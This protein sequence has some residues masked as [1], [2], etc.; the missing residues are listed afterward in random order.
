MLQIIMAA[1]FLLL[2]TAT[3]VLTLTGTLGS[4]E[5][6]VSDLID[7]MI[8]PSM[9]N[10]MKIITC[11]GS[12]PVLC[13]LTVLLVLL[14]QTRK[15]FGCPVAVTAM[16]SAAL[17]LVLKYCFQRPRPEVML[18]AETGYSFPSG[19]AQSGMAFF[20]AVALLIFCNIGRLK[21]S[22]PLFVFCMLMPLL[23][24]FSRLYFG[25]HYA[26]DVLAGWVCGAFLAVSV[27]CL[28]KI[29]DGKLKSRQGIHRFFFS[30]ST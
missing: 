13:G 22:V 21:Y 20:L 10:A 18:I 5:A 12:F 19:H 23:I 29:L 17:N 4:F 25:V 30:R 8:T 1:V 16:I 9:S 15:R 3:A 7:Q 14:P 27:N 24:G 11:A 2:F 26:G 28:W 6:A